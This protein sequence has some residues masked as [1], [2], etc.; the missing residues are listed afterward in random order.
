MENKTVY[1][2]CSVETFLNIIRNATL[3]LTDVEKSNDY[4]E[5]TFMEALIIEELQKQ[6][7]QTALGYIFNQMIEENYR[8]LY[9][10]ANLYACCFSEEKDLLSQWRAYAGNGTGV[11]IGFS[12]KYLERTD[13]DLYGLKFRK[14]NYDPEQHRI[15]AKEQVE[16]I[17]KS[18][19]A[20]KNFFAAMGDVFENRIE[21]NSCRKKPAFAEEKEWRLSIAMSPEARIGRTGVFQDFTLSEIK[22][23]SKKDQ[24]VTYFDLSFEKIKQQFIK[25][26]VIGPDCKADTRDFYH[27]LSMFQYDAN[28]VAISKSEATYRI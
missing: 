3:R 19:E 20:G 26:I 10:N 27:C 28:E 7:E 18:M 5:R 13:Q 4:A 21:E 1:H 25:E 22:V 6:S 16:T 23:Y 9:S 11:A 2:Y 14:V 17:I 12:G 8:T 15:Y 24:L